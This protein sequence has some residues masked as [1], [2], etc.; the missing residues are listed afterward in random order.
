[1]FATVR[2]S[3]QHIQIACVH[4]PTIERLFIMSLQ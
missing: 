2:E 1:L 3:P 4:Q